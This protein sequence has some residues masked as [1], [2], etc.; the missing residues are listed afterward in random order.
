ME[1]D[2]GKERKTEN[3][4]INRSSRTVYE[5]FPLLREREK[6]EGREE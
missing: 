2:G 5:S 4:K 6:E 3:E 1:G